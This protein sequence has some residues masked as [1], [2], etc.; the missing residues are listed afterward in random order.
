MRFTIG[1]W[2]SIIESVNRVT[3]SCFDTFLKNVMVFPKLCSFFFSLY[4]IEIR[5]Y[6]LVHDVSSLPG[7]YEGEATIILPDHVK[8][9][10]KPDAN[11]NTLIPE[12][13]IPCKISITADTSKNV[14]LN[15]VDFTMPV[16]GITVNPAL[17]K[18]TETD[19]T[20]NLEGGGKVSV[21]QETISYTHKG[22]V[23]EDQLN[24]DIT[25]TVIPMIVEPKIV[26]KGK[27]K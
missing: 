22:K 16:K 8:A 5:G 21:G 23:T 26:F 10:L 14:T 15:L 9:M 7:L 18:V 25:V 6:F 13:P 19:S 3:F 11:G 20:L 4:K 27:K 12:G 2:W 17:S 24:L 1:C